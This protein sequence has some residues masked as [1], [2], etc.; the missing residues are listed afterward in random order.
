MKRKTNNRIL[1]YTMIAITVIASYITINSYYTQLAIYQEKEL[2][3]LDCIANAV[4]YKIS[5]DEHMELVEKYPPSIEEKVLESDSV[6]KKIFNQMYMAQVMTQ[7]PSSMQTIV[8]LDTSRHFY[9]AISTEDSDWLM[10]LNHGNIPDSIYEK[11]GMI[12]LYENNEEKRLGAASPV[13]N[14]KGEVIGVLKV[15]ET[16]DSFFNKAKDQI[17]MNILITLAFIAVIGVMMFYSVKNLLRQQ[18]K[19]QKERQ[20]LEQFRQ[21]LMAN[22]SHDL[23]T[24]LAGIHGYIETMIIK[25]NEMDEE[26]CQRYLQNALQSTGKLKYLVDEL[27]EL[28]RLESRERKIEIQDFS[29]RELAYDVVG[30]FKMQAKDKNVALEVESADNIPSVKADLALIDRVLQNLISNALKYCEAGDKVVLALRQE[31]NKVRVSVIDTGS[32]IAAE[33]LPRL[34]DRFYKGK[35]SQPGTGLGLAIV[36]SILNMHGSECTVESRLNVGTT[37]SFTLDI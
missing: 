10:R 31:K 1:V 8:K 28:S 33:D 6:Y 3:K 35:S 17:Y 9:Q 25:K 20:E 12:G 13:I 19:L 21:E 7:V 30:N 14:N 27:F 23:R 15:E 11:G 24:P 2:F 37:F 29:I 22:V 36:K 34:F 26:T 32:G 18:E 4:A 16:F 5:G